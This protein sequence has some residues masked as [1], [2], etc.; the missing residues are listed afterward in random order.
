[1]RGSRLS[2]TGTSL[3]EL[4]K[5]SSTLSSIPIGVLVDQTFYISK[6]LS[7]ARFWPTWAHGGTL[8]PVSLDGV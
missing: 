8:L 5:A 7:C 3:F 4:A 1:M 6:P 2:S